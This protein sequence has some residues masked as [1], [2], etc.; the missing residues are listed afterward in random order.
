MPS[1]SSVRA[2]SA[3]S[4]TEK[5]MPGVWAPHP[6]GVTYPQMH[7]LIQGLCRKGRVVGMD[8]NEITPVYDIN[9]AT[10]MAAGRFIV[11]LIGGA[12]HNGYFD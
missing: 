5:S 4:S 12:V 1:R 11:N 10:C 6:G 3:L 7:T 8:V 9:Q 2:I